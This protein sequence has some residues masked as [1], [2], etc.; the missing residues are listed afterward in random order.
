MKLLRPGLNFRKAFQSYAE[1]LWNRK[2]ARA[3]Y[4]LNEEEKAK[5]IACIAFGRKDMQNLFIDMGVSMKKN[6]VNALIDA[7]D[8]NGDGVVTMAEFLEFT[9]PTRDKN[10]GISSTLKKKCCWRTTCKKVLTCDIKKRC[11]CIKKTNAVVLY[12]R[13]CRMLMQSQILPKTNFAEREKTS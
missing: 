8:S 2:Q 5:M 13:V 12:R 10:S 1:K 6:E 7:F 4:D 11:V 3:D 9:G